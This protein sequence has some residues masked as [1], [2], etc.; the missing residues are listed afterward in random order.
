MPPFNCCSIYLKKV[1]DFSFAIDIK[2]VLKTDHFLFKGLQN[3]LLSHEVSIVTCLLAFAVNNSFIPTF[4]STTGTVDINL[5][6]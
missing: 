2:V 5:K 6:L 1:W 4:L 3:S